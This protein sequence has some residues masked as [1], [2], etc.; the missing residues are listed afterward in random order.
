[1][2]SLR[3][4]PIS[5][6]R[7]IAVIMDGNGRW[8]RQKGLPRI[9]GHDAAEGAIHSSVEVCGELGVEFLTLYA[10]STENWSRPRAEVSFIMQLLS[11]FIRNNIDEL[12]RKNVRLR[13]SGRI[14]DLPRGPR[15]ELQIAVER[16]S[17]NK[18]LTLVLALSYGGRA[19]IR[20]AVAS[21]AEMVEQGGISSGMITEETI[22]SFMYNPDIPDPEL[23]IRTS[24]E[25]RLSNFLMWESAYS[26]FVFSSVLWPDF[27]GDELRRAIEEY[28]SRKRRFG[29]VES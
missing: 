15:K 12:D 8:A 4:D 19:E 27:N 21:I 6:P 24:G 7:H 29:G 20:D 13:T 1:M 28:S 3:S 17:A 11:R 23:I 5:V 16:T 18:G 14:K 25:Q 26:E 10:F 22:G 2:R 9:K